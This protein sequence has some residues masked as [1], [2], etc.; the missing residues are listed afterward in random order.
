MLL[1]ACAASMLN[2]IRAKSRNAVRSVTLHKCVK[3]YIITPLGDATI[4]I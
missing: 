4:R 3:F 2:L 1:T